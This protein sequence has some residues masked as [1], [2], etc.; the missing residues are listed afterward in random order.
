[1]CDYF[2]SNNNGIPEHTADYFAIDNVITSVIA[3]VIAALIYG[4][5][6][7]PLEEALMLSVVLASTLRPVFPTVLASEGCPVFALPD[8]LLLAE[9]WAELAEALESWLWG[10]WCPFSKAKRMS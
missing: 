5:V 2:L 8:E 10:G 1:M 6:C 4:R 9:R 3:N 7:L